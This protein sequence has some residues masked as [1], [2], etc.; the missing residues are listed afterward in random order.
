MG[1]QSL[2]LLTVLAISAGIF[3]GCGGGGT[4]SAGAVTSVNGTKP[5]NTLT[6]A[7]STQLCKDSGAYVGRAV[8]KVNACKA[9]ALV[10]TALGSPTTEAQARATCAS[11]YTPCLS[12]PAASSSMD[13]CDS[14]PA[15]CTATVAQYSAC[16]SDP[17]LPPQ[18]GPPRGTTALPA[19]SPPPLAKGTRGGADRTAGRPPPPNAPPRTAACPPQEPTRGLNEAN[20]LAGGPRPNKGP[21]TP[22]GAPVENFGGHY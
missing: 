13:T 4:G 9:L 20:D 14:I 17:D 19:H 7:E 2:S 6:A 12:A 18:P 16:F 3:L 15:T 1:K 5:L 11:I 21:P 22:P 8:S 10:L